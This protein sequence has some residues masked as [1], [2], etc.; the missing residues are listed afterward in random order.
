MSSAT[1]VT[2][3][4]PFLK[5]FPQLAVVEWRQF[6]LQ[7]RVGMLE[8]GSTWQREGHAYCLLVTLI[9][10]VCMYCQIVLSYFGE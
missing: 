8:S 10:A 4:L 3:S 2:C 7:L 9:M 1:D 5:L 6:H